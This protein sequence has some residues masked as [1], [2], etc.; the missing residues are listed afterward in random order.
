MSLIT[1]NQVMNV[2]NEYICVIRGI[3]PTHN[4]MVDINCVHYSFFQHNVLCQTAHSN[5]YGGSKTPDL[6]AGIDCE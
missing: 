5:G 2:L 6:K 1:F 4:V 3:L